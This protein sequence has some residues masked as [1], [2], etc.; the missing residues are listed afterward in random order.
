M[1]LL[2]SLHS[3]VTW[4]SLLQSSRPPPYRSHATFCCV[5]WPSQI[6]S[7]ELLLSPC[8]SC[9]VFF[10]K[11]PSS[12]V[13]IKFWCLTCITLSISLP[14]VY[15]SSTLLLSVLLTEACGFKQLHNNLCMSFWVAIEGI[16]FLYCSYVYVCNC[17][18]NPNSQEFRRLHFKIIFV[19]I[20]C[21][22][23]SCPAV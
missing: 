4:P 11:E 6:A 15:L 18:K 1:D 19:P 2:P 20:I 3:L 12:H 14:L 13:C 16:V 5:A 23:F 21:L 8:L 17:T 9:G 7:L 10:F 22:F